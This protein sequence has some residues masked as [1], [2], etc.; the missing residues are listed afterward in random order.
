MD[1]IVQLPGLPGA[2]VSQRCWRSIQLARPMLLNSTPK[3]FAYDMLLLSKLQS[4]STMDSQ[5]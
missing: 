3:I 1:T 5:V 4:E 2:Y